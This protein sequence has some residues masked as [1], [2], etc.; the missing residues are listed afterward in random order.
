M[1]CW[2]TLVSERKKTEIRSTLKPVHFITYVRMDVKVYIEWVTLWW[3][4]SL[5]AEMQHILHVDPIADSRAKLVHQDNRNV[6][7]LCNRTYVHEPLCTVK[8]SRWGSGSQRTFFFFLA[9]GKKTTKSGTGSKRPEPL[10]KENCGYAI[11]RPLSRPPILAWPEL[12]VRM[13]EKRLPSMNE[14]INYTQLCCFPLPIFGRW[15]DFLPAALSWHRLLLLLHRCIISSRSQPILH[16]KVISENQARR[17]CR[18]NVCN[19]AFLAIVQRWTSLSFTFLKVK[20]TFK[21]D[22]QFERKLNILPSVFRLQQLF[23]LEWMMATD[24]FLFCFF[25]EVSVV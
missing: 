7:R 13:R 25:L 2:N 10:W 21:S 18:Y 19:P 4:R 24:V 15:G 11:S 1:F 5:R 23:M 20:I 9:M 6:N 17:W 8:A 12:T 3:R 16:L 22:L 14:I